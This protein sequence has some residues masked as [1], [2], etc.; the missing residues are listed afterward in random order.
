MANRR[1][2]NNE[3]IQAGTFRKDRHSLKPETTE[4]RKLN[5]IPDAPIYFDDYARE[6]WQLITQELLNRGD[7]CEV[8]LGQ[9]EQYAY[10][11]SLAQR[12]AKELNT[13]MTTASK[14]NP[15][16]SPFFRIYSQAC[17]TVMDIG[18]KFG[19]NSRSKLSIPAADS[20][21]FANNTPDWN[22]HT[23]QANFNMKDPDD[24]AAYEAIC[25]DY[26]KMYPT[27]MFR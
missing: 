2:S 8:Y 15:A 14:A 18:D 10:S 17:K 11:L 16:V 23:I 1:K 12:A 22:P 19:F 6:A 7:L 26:E 9:L 3:H 13:T 21:P 27:W 24:K 20:N 25:E 5:N 4:W